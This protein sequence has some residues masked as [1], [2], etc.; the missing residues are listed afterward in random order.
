MWYILNMAEFYI[1]GQLLDRVSQD[2]SELSTI[3]SPDAVEPEKYGAVCKNRVFSLRPQCWC[4][5][6]GCPMCYPS[7]SDNPEIGVRAG[8]LMPNFWHF[9]SGLRIWW[10]KTIGRSMEANRSC[11]E[12]EWSAI[13]QKCKESLIG[14]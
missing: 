9:K 8:E 3:I 10:Y 4:E 1:S 12:G 6:P 11:T 7:E 5:S 2:I 13:F 14:M